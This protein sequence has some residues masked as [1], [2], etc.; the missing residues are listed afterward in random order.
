MKEDPVDY[1]AAIDGLLKRAAAAPAAPA[2]YDVVPGGW[3]FHNGEKPKQ[4]PQLIKKI[5]PEVGIGLMSGQWG[6]YK[7]TIA[8]DMSVSVMGLDTFADTYKVKRGGAV[9]YFALE[10]GNTIDSRLSIIAERRGVKG[11]LPFAWRDDCPPLLDQASADKLCQLVEEAGVEIKSKFDLDVVL[12]WLDTLM[13]AARYKSGEEN[14]FAA[15]GLAMETMRK[16]SKRFGALVIALD[17]FGKSIETGTRGT[18]AK[19][20]ASDV[21]LA[22]LAEREVSGGVKNTRMAVRKLR[23]GI[24]GFEIPFSPHVIEIGQDE[25]GDPITAVLINWQEAQEA[26]KQDKN[27]WTPSLHVLKRVLISSLDG[28]TEIRPFLDGP[29]VRACNTETV[30]EEFY[31][32]YPAD[33]TQKQKAAA[34]RQ[35]FNRS[36]KQAIGRELVVTREIDG[37]QFIWLAKK[38]DPNA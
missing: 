1:Q 17:H 35:A 5:F 26:S 2:S 34:R 37:T 30:R 28:G 38:E 16:I 25:D 8:L 23:S 18:S 10:G 33:G 31:R 13:I 12:I 21:V 20:D 4:P 19:E 3:K 24:S 15:G 14:D 6:T 32:Q 7:T 36:L 9:L 29:Q 27:A 11:E 22:L